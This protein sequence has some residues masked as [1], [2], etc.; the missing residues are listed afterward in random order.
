MFNTFEQGGFAI[1]IKK[2]YN[3]ID[4]GKVLYRFPHYHKLVRGTSSNFL[5]KH[6]CTNA[7]KKA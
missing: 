7:T 1:Y 2:C 3:Y 6:I 5:V 4:V